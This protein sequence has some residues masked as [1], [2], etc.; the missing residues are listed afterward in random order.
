M[1]PSAPWSLA[2][3][4]PTGFTCTTRGDVSGG[5]VTPA[6][7]KLAALFAASHAA[8]RPTCVNVSSDEHTELILEARGFVRSGAGQ[9]IVF[10]ILRNCAGSRK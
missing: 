5:Y 2:S 9:L 8:C 1:L 10:S 7:K 4:T 3:T 6:C